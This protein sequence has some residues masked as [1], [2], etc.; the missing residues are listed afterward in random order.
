MRLGF[1]FIAAL[2]VSEVARGVIDRLRDETG[3]SAQLVIRDGRDAVVVLNAVGAGAFSTNVSVGARIPAH[4]TVLGRMLLC[5]LT[6]AELA[7]LY[8]ESELHC[9][10]PGAPRTLPQ[11]KAL[12][13]ED[14]ARGYAVSE[15]CFDQEITALVAP[16]RARDGTFVATV[17]VT[18]CAPTRRRDRLVRQVLA[19]ASAISAGLHYRSA[20]A[21]A[22]AR[23]HALDDPTVAPPVSS[24]NARRKPPV[25]PE[26]RERRRAAPR[27]DISLVSRRADGRE[28]VAAGARRTHKNR[29]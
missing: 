29:P 17:S 23:R 7:C 25:S 5:E 2:E 16:V 24:T 12:L 28:S 27:I 1:E 14:L 4:A 11:L 19:A 20:E 3:C 18:V 15:S 8:A 13:C 22:P 10:S 6:D 21:H 26:G 9:V